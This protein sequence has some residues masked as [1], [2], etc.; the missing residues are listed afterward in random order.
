MNK[1]EVIRHFVLSNSHLP[2]QG[3]QEWK[4]AR[5]HFIGGS[6]VSTILKKNKNKTV[7]KL[8]LEK[9]GFHR[10]SGNSATFWGNVFEPLIRQFT[11]HYFSCSIIETGSIP[12]RTSNLSYSPDGIAYVKK[13][14]LKSIV[15][16]SQLSNDH[17]HIVLF[18]FKCPHSRIPN[19]EI[20]EHYVPQP[21]IGM[22]IIDICEVGIFIEAIYRRCAFYDLQ[23]NTKHVAF[24]HYNRTKLT[25]NPVEYG[26]LCIYATVMTEQIEMILDFLYESDTKKVK[27]LYD[28]GTLY[29]KD[30]FDQILEL[31][32]SGELQIDYAYN[33]AYN[34]KTFQS[35][36]YIIDN[37]NKA[38]YHETSKC[39]EQQKKDHMIHTIIGILPYKLIEVH[40]HP[41]YKDHHYIDKH[42]LVDKSSSIIEFMK[43]HQ[44]ATEKE[45]IDIL[46]RMK[47]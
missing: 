36:S 11:N 1:R 23:Y 45:I 33:Q 8:I 35:Y 38:V 42:K 41:V 31:C 19:G 9:M 29:D 21:M 2:K 27:Q 24:G 30:I 4:N 14:H 28:L 12:Y 39:I 47:L 15:D 44:S 16:V 3:T 25:K 7:R 46:K 32:V 37:Y 34:P 26:F 40:I 18:E 6:E 22:N 10:F 43:K 20:P 13:E 5:K 17:D